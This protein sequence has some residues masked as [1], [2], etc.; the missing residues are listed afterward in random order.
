MLFRSYKQ[1]SFLVIDDFDNFLVS[2][3]QMLR[4]MGAEQIDSARN[5]DEAIELCLRRHYDIVFCDYNMGDQHKNGQQVLEE[6][7]Y[8]GLIKHTDLF[9]MVS[10]EASRDMVMG[11]LEYQ[12]DGYITKPITQSVLQAR[13]DK[14]FSQKI[15]THE[16]NRAMDQ[17]DYARGISLVNTQ[18]KVDPKNRSWLLNTLGT[19]YILNGDYAHA[20]KVYEDVIKQRPLDWAQMG[21]G[22]A[23]YLEGNVREA[24]A[25]FSALIEQSPHLVGAYDW[26]AK[27]QRETGQAR[28]AQETIQEAVNISPRAIL[29]QQELAHLSRQLNDLEVAAKAFKASTKLSD[30]SCYES[31]ELYLDHARTLNDLAETSSAPKDVARYAQDAITALE[32]VKRKYDDA[33][34]LMRGSL[35]EARGRHYQ[36]HEEASRNA[37]AQARRL[38]SETETGEED[39]DL[40][41]EMAETH[42]AIGATEEANTLL[43]DFAER[44]PGNA[45]LQT[46]V[47]ELL[48]E[49]VSAIQRQQARTLNR[50]GIALYEQ[51]KLTEALAQFEKAL[52]ITPKQPGLN[53]NYLQALAKQMAQ[54]ESPEALLQQARETLSRLEGLSEGHRQYARYQQIRKRYQDLGL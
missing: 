24:A 48:E 17:Q 46:R 2:M 4:R 7:R 39:L 1:K 19:L 38:L 41:L 3:K 14:L 37:A 5:G 25:T 28:K 31:P 15:A 44:F 22:K 18:I 34:V 33:R 32:P 52:A 10:A 26:L 36:K 27:C 11:A 45:T 23:L 47:Q 53:L 49:P 13:L 50:E 43:R 6:L 9:I 29:R 54:V 20:K 51:E 35:A 12:P 42:F 21:L 40:V 30:K 8:R 16:I